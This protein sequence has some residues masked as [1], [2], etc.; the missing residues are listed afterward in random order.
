MTRTRCTAPLVTAFL[1]AVATIAAAEP[2]RLA[3]HPDYYAGAITFSYLGDIWIA[4]EDGSGVRRL[5]DHPARDT[6]PRFSPDGRWI[7]FSSARYGNNDVFVMPSGGGAP[8]RLTFHTGS[9]DVVGWSRDSQRVLFR[10]TR[11]DGAFP[12]VAVLYEIAATG[13][14]EKPMSFK[15]WIPAS[16]GMTT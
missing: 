5:T 4:K 10:A 13:G 16:A 8:R 14:Q 1:V 9:D 6:F 15:T 7:A 11:G 3:R 2:V 12:T